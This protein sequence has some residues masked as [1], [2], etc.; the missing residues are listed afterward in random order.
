M[1]EKKGNV[2]PL[3]FIL[4]L[5][6]TTFIFIFFVVVLFQMSD[7]SIDEK[8][9]KAQAVLSKIFNG[10]CFSQDFATVEEK[11]FNEKQLNECFKNIDET[12]LFR[13]SIENNE[14]EKIS[15]YIYAGN[16]E[17]KFD[18]KRSYCIESNML[19]S[20][21]T[22]PITYIDKDNQ[23]SSKILVVEIISF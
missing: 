18:D 22:Y 9:I 4:I 10:R 13:V 11:L 1:I 21:M 15:K 8:K 5:L 12:M 7:L 20:K 2:D 16:N 17:D 23:Y 3:K 14:R 19:C 6:I